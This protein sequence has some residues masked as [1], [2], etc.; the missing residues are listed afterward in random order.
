MSEYFL[1]GRNEGG[2]SMDEK[3]MAPSGHANDCSS[4][5][6]CFRLRQVR[7]FLDSDLKE[8]C[9]TGLR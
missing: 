1:A 5:M 3:V 4:E 8:C 6:I 7:L 2:A 9:K